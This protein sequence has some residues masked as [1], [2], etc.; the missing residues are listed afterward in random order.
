MNSQSFRA[1]SRTR[2]A[3][4]KL[5]LRTLVPLGAAALVTSFAGSAAAI[6]TGNQQQIEPAPAPTPAPRRASSTPAPAKTSST[7]APSDSGGLGVSGRERT[8][9]APQ[10][11]PDRRHAFDSRWWAAAMLGFASDVY[12]GGIG[13]RFGKSLDMHLYI[14]GSFVYHFGESTSIPVANPATGQ[15]YTG[16]A[17]TSAFYTGPEVGYDFDL[18]AVVLRPYM[19]IGVANIMYSQS[20]N[21]PGVPGASYSTSNLRFVVWPGCT[22]NW[23]IPHSSFFIGG[24]V[25]VVSVPDIAFSVFGFGGLYF[26]DGSASSSSVASR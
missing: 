5:S 4:L 20:A 10:E 7:S 23:T 14:G 11:S 13:A 9:A 18:R 22:V 21:V 17:S 15:I 24:D 26:G 2:P 1:S 25:R 3:S 19:G 12:Q 16:S 6:E 8:E